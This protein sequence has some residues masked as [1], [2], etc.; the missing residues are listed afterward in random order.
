M[1]EVRNSPSHGSDL[2]KELAGHNKQCIRHGES[3]SAS[4]LGGKDSESESENEGDVLVCYLW[5]T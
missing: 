4:S 1:K 3:D 2:N 5:K